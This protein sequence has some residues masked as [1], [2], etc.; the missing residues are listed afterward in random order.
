LSNHLALRVPNIRAFEEKMARLKYEKL[1]TKDSTL[2]TR[3]PQRYLRDPDGHVV[4]I[5][6]ADIPAADI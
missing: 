6:A 5:N 3:Y 2:P 1:V 4:E